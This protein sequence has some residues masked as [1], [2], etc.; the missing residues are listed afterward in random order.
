MLGGGAGW[1]WTE[2]MESLAEDK[3]MGI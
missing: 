2:E 1:W 3:K